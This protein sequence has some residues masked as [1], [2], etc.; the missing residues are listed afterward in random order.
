MEMR[1]DITKDGKGCKM[2]RIKKWKEQLIVLSDWVQK[3]YL[4]CAIIVNIL[5]VLWGGFNYI[6][7]VSDLT[8]L[9]FSEEQMK[10]YT[11]NKSI[12]GVVDE[13]YEA[14]LYDII[15]DMFLEKGYYSYTVEFEGNS[16]GS[17]CWP[18][19]YEKFYDIIE[20][21]TVTLGEERTTGSKKFWLNADLNIALRLFY[22]GDGTV[23][24]KSFVI[25]EVLL[26]NAC[27]R[28]EMLSCIKAL[29]YLGKIF[30][31]NAL[32]PHIDWKSGI[33]FKTKKRYT[34]GD[35]WTYALYR[36]KLAHNVLV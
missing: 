26:S 34:R 35:L 24:F 10:Q 16:D 22:N 7:Q 17:F 23:T 30:L 13:K 12:G 2:G 19:T 15:P 4:L 6:Q 25:E 11:A 14:G 8:R 28:T 9:E 5:I 31:H 20:Q 36:T 32:Y 21:Q 33:T 3:K 27:V 1:F 18:H 29:G